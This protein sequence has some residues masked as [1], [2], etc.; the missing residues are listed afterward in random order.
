MP[1]I[2]DVQNGFFKERECFLIREFMV[3]LS[4]SGGCHFELIDHDL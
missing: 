2:Q 1:G 3:S 4:G